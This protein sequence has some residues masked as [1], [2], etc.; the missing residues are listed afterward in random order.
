MTHEE[1]LALIHK[2]FETRRLD[3]SYMWGG[4]QLGCRD[5]LTGRLLDNYVI[6]NGRRLY[7]FHMPMQVGERQLR[8]AQS[9]MWNGC[10][11]QIDPN[12]DPA[13]YGRDD[14]DA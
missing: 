14:D 5:S 1:R 3:P 9:I 2:R 10:D 7:W 6:Q 11:G 4:A 13:D 8:Q 12:D